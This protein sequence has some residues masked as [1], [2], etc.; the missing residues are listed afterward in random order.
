MYIYYERLNMSKS[1]LIQ[2]ASIML[3]YAILACLIG[4][5]LF[6]YTISRTVNGA[7]NGFIAGSILSIVLWL[8]V[9]KKMIK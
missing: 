1:I 6:Y 7:G 5:L 2:F 4:P 3:F 8:T 9:G